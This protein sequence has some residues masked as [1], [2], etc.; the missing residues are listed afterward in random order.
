MIPFRTYV[1]QQHGVVTVNPPAYLAWVLLRDSSGCQVYLPV[2]IKQGAQPHIITVVNYGPAVL[3][4][5][6]NGTALAYLGVFHYYRSCIV[7]LSVL[8]L[9]LEVHVLSNVQRL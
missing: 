8:R 7:V 2:H 4:L 3:P 5:Q 1:A 6:L 9:T